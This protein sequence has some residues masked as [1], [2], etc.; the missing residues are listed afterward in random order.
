[1]ILIVLIGGRVKEKMKGKRKKCIILLICFVCIILLLFIFEPRLFPGI[2]YPFVDF[3][4]D[5][6]NPVTRN[7]R[8]EYR[9]VGVKYLEGFSVGFTHYGGEQF[10]RRSF[11]YVVSGKPYKK[12][13]IK[14]YLMRGG[15][16]GGVFVENISQ[17]FSG[18]IFNDMLYHFS[19]LI[20]EMNHDF[21]SGTKWWAK[22]DTGWYAAYFWYISDEVNFH[23]IFKHKK[24][25]DKFIFKI[26]YEYSWDDGPMMIQEL[27]YNVEAVKG[28]YRI[29]HT[30]FL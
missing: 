20:T 25:G 27:K 17:T 15:G 3:E 29:P 6:V 4:I 24:P 28:A 30:F 14:K 2:R 1:M 12:L 7:A 21:P 16:T 23:K 5:E 18:F 19:G 10:K 11:E 8:S 13:Y 22:Y 9:E 26:I